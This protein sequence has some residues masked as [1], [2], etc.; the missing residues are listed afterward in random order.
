MRKLALVTAAAMMTVA[1]VGSAAAMPLDAG[2]PAELG[3]KRKCAPGSKLRACQPRARTAAVR[4]PRPIAR[5]YDSAA[6]TAAANNASYVPPAQAPAP[7]PAPAQVAT[8]TPQAPAPAAAGIAPG[9]RAAVAVAAFTA[10]LLGLIAA[11]SGDT[12]PNGPPPTTDP[13]PDPTSP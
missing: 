8:Y 4:R 11:L 12:K 6:E 2:N 10:F 9:A 7:A 1:Q 5:P 3:M 13:G